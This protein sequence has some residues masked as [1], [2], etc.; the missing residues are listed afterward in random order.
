[1]Q[2]PHVLRHYR[3]NTVHTEKS[4]TGFFFGVEGGIDSFSARTSFVR[5]IS[6]VIS[7]YDLLSDSGLRLTPSGRINLRAIT[8]SFPLKIG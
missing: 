3:Q 7:S 5:G 2:N 6:S 8:D 1:M 4:D